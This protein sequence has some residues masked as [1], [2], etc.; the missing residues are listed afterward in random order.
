M[1]KQRIP[2]A[3]GHVVVVQRPAF[4]GAEHILAEAARCP[5]LFAQR[6]IHRFI[7]LDLALRPFGLGGVLLAEH[8]RLAH[9]D[10]VVR[11]I[12]VLPL[13]PVDLAGTHPGE[14]AHRVVMAVIRA[15]GGEDALD[16]LQAERRDVALGDLEG[17]DV[18]IGRM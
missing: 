9:Q 3:L 16:F 2:H 14:K 15:N 4:A 12:D 8:D 11:E 18:A 6:L 1:A 17:P 13:Q 10:L 5:L 7:H